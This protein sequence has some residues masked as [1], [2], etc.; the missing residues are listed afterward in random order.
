MF[1]NSIEMCAGS[2]RVYI[3]FQYQ[4]LVA[5]IVYIDKVSL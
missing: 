5:I 2:Q 4:N 1:S 3:F